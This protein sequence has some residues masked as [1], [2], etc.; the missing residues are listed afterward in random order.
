MTIVYRLRPMDSLLD[1]HHEL[2]EQELALSSP[3]YFNDPL[4]GY[5]DVFWDGD[6][7]LWENLLRNYLLNLLWGTNT[8]L[9]WDDDE[10]YEYAVRPGLTAEDLPTDELRK[11]YESVC[12]GFFTERGFQSIPAKLST[13]PQPLRK[14]SLQLVLSSI[15]P[16]AL[17]AVLETLRDDGIISSDLEIEETKSSEAVEKIL[18]SLSTAMTGKSETEVIESLASLVNPLQSYAAL[19]QEV[20]KGKDELNHHTKKNIFLRASFPKKYV[21]EITTSL[22]HTDWHTL[23]FVKDC[24]SP[25]MWATYADE[26]RGAALMFHADNET[27][28]SWGQLTVT[29]RTGW[30]G[31]EPKYG[32]ITAPLYEVDYESPPPEVDF[33]RFLGQLPMPKLMSAWHS[34]PEG[35]TSPVVEE[36]LED[37]DAWRESLWD[38]FHNMTTRKLKQWEHEQ[39]VRM[40]LSDM[41]NS[42]GSHKKVTYDMSQLEGIVF[43]LRTD[44]EDRFEVMRILSEKGSDGTSLPV[45]FYEMVFDG[46]EFKKV[47]LNV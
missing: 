15:H 3:R 18:D 35:E 17:Q 14:K 2:E 10:F 37:Q 28:D 8:C 22:I 6:E 24:T 9:I 4:E 1:E 32:E 40:V 34:T 44:L 43:G 27:E 31:S 16:S 20:Q 19:N 38:H 7:I 36:I 47:K 39:E 41:F 26:H 11:L 45:D 12:E 46:T 42:E 13:L 25:P 29:G 33:F 30:H 5:Q 21:R 23:C